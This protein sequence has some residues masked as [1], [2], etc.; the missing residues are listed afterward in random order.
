[1][2]GPAELTGTQKKGEG[3]RGSGAKRGDLPSE[4]GLLPHSFRGGPAEQPPRAYRIVEGQGSPA[5]QGSWENMR[6]A[7]HPK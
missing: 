2:A 3:R 7:R 6:Q 4:G 5:A 1:M